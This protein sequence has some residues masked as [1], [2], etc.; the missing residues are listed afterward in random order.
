VSPRVVVVGDAMLDVV[1]RPL[2]PFAPT[3]DTPA[4]VRVLRGGSG[5]NLAVALRAAAAGTLDIVFAGIVGRDAAALIVRADLEESGVV[6]HLASAEGSTGVVVSLVGDVGER[7]MMTERGVNGELV[8]E[9]VADVLDESLVHLHVSGYTVL[10][11]AT[12][13]LVTRL[14][15]AAAASGATTSVD[16]CSVGPLVTLGPATF[17]AAIR[18]ATMLFANEEEALVLSGGDDVDVALEILSRQWREVVITRGARG[19]LARRGE[20]VVT[21]AARSDDVVDTTGAGDSAT[22]TYLAHRLA[23]DDLETSLRY[24]MDAAARVVRGLGSQG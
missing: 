10:D 16:V 19:A 13:V 12:R 14:L 1:V 15:E 23:G 21:A 8:F 3:S 22:G 18:E 9:H 2:A 6:A 20:E 17:A 11:A 4:R 5:A 7:A 24:A